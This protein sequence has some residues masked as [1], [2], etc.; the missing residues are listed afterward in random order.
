M[1]VEE[2]I[3]RLLFTMFKFNSNSF[4]KRS[5]VALAN[6]DN[7]NGVKG[8]F[9]GLKVDF[10]FEQKKISQRNKKLHVR[11][12]FFNWAGLVKKKTCVS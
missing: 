11:P 1:N 9:L 10:T 7:V 12:V 6:Q 5:Q 8:R 3:H 2:T 4:L